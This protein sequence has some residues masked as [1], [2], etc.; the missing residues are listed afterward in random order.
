[1]I[2]YRRRRR[3]AAKLQPKFVGPYVVVEAMPNHTYK[4]E[5]SGQ[6]SIQNEARLKPYWTSSDAV[7]EALPLLEPRR[8]TTTRWRRRHRPE[9]EV[10]IPREEDLARD[11][12]PLPPAEVR[13][14]PPTPG[15]MPSLPELDPDLEVQTST[16]GG[17]QSGEIGEETVTRG[18]ETPSVELDSSPVSAPPPLERGQHTR[19]PS[20][21]LKDFVCDCVQTGAY[22]SLA[23]NSTE[24]P[25]SNCGSCEPHGNT[26]FYI[27]GTTNKIYP[28]GVRSHS[29][30]PQPRCSIFSY[31]DAVK[32]R[33]ATSH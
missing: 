25:S 33:R 19:Q 6:V 2:N 15:L 12:R 27:G 1:M 29:H 28:P 32:S 31:A 18:P 14:P 4:I 13:L 16:E 3:Q 8:Q 23:G 10:A 11:E 7:G 20:E 17:A 22:E 5:R 30:A 9:Y 26:N 24:N 21:Y